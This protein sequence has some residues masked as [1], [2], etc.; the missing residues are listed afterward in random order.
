V[1]TTYHC[2]CKPGYVGTRC[3]VCKFD[4]E[5][6]IGGWEKT[7]TAFNNQPTYGDNPTARGYSSPANQ[8]G[9]WWIGGFEDRPSK[10]TPPGLSQGDD[11]QGTLTSPQF[12]I[13]GKNISFLIGGACNES[14]SRAELI[15]NSLVVRKASSRFC[16]EEMTRTFWDVAAFIGQ[17]ARVKLIDFSSDDWGHINFDDLR[18][19]MSCE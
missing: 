19:D 2:V 7:G 18:G 5:D 15:V 17:R 3:E 12:T 8:Q 4:F 13:I 14:F 6:G 10:E 11:P 9:D 1:R 16:T